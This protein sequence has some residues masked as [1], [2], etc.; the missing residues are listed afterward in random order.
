MF[1]KKENTK[2]TFQKLRNLTIFSYGFSVEEEKEI[3]VPL[4]LHRV[5]SFKTEHPLGRKG[6]S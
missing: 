2:K 6:M 5:F 4:D 1:N 3:P